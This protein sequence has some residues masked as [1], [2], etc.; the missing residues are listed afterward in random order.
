MSSSPET[1]A[2][3]G[4]DVR[5]L[6]VRY[7]DDTAVDGLSFEVLLEEGRDAEAIGRWQMILDRF[8]TYED[9]DDIEQKIR[10]ALGIED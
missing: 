7:G 4:I 5:D 1:Q 3:Q 8:P 6:T 9:Y 10:K 2:S